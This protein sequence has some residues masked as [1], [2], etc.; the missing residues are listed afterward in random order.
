MRAMRGAVVTALVVCASESTAQLNPH[1]SDSRA[2]MQ[3]RSLKC[4][5]PW[6][7]SASWE[8][9]Q[10]EVKTAEQKGFEFHIDGIDYKQTKARIIG[11]AGSDDLAAMSGTDSVSFLEQTPFGA[12]NL[13]TV[14]AWRDKG[15]RFKAVHS[16]HTAIGG[17]S[18][19]QNYGFCQPWE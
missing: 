7:A 8:S 2:L 18:P 3:S 4:S 17:P 16:R 5:F 13:T 19:S 9:D 6:Y 10:P 1:Q 14:Y 15:G 12:T 11:N